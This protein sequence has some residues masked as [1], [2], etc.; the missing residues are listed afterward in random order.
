[1]LTRLT[2]SPRA[3]TAKLEN[4][5]TIYYGGA[6]M[7]LEDIKRAIAK[8]GPR[9][10][11][12]FGQGESPMTGTG[13][14]K[15]LHADIDNPR[16]EQRL[17]STG[18]A[19]TG[20]EIR[21]VGP[22]GDPLPANEPGEVLLRSEVTM[23]GYWNN[24]QATEAAI[25]D[26]W[27]HTGDIGFLDEDGFLTLRDRAK[28]MIISGA[29]NI[30]PR[31]I[32]EVLLTDRRIFEVSVVGRPHPDWGE[33]VVAF[34]VPHTNETI[35]PEELDQVCLE[36]IARFKRPKAY[37]FL[38]NLPKSSYGKILK[39]ELREIMKRFTS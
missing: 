21:V 24:S 18:T 32:E 27:L 16:Y 35:T 12:I 15:S 4:I 30:Y 13:L 8:F 28:D 25:R 9:L 3:A 10:Y 1:M 38:E 20:V 7:Y 26:G 29:S 33:E 6:P 23:L 11:Q 36:N 5:K 14:S 2:N 17:A 19:R 22:G 37:F 39:S 34:I 31:E